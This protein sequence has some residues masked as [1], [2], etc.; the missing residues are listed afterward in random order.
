[1]RADIVIYDKHG[2]LAAII[3]TKNKKGASKDWAIKLR[4]NLYEHG[5]WPKT[6]YFLLV[7]PDRLYIWKNAANT[8]EIIEPDYE[9]NITEFFKSYYERLNFSPEEIGQMG[10]DSFELLVMSW[11]NEIARSS[12]GQKQ[13]WL[14]QSELLETIKTGRIVS[15]VDI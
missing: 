2:Q 4:R 9:I 10:A 14:A 3:E 5:V 8:P 12:N 6:P 7:L 11:L 1:M 13:D 15:E